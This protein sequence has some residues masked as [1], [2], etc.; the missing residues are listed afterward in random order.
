MELLERVF[1]SFDIVTGAKH[2]RQLCLGEAVDFKQMHSRL[3]F[4]SGDCGGVKL[5]VTDDIGLVTYLPL[6]YIYLQHLSVL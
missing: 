1:L 6:C 2:L 4:D 3:R 5:V